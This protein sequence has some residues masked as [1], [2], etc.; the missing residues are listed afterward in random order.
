MPK[1]TEAHLEARRQQIV[2]AAFACFARNGFHRTTM[3]DICQEAELSPG[4][5]YHYFDSKEAII[6]ASIAECQR[7]SMAIIQG[8]VG[9][10]RTLQVLDE[11]L[12]CLSRLSE[13]DARD[14]IRVGV[15]LWAEALRNPRVSEAYRRMSYDVWREALTRIASQGQQQGEIDEDLDPEAVAQVL[16]S[17]WH[18]LGLQKGIDPDLDIAGYS[19]VVR[20]MYGGTFWRDG[21]EE[22]MEENVR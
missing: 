21:G 8:A 12:T 11:L 5:V 7:Q 15:E 2:D 10:G 3:Q 19:Q 17:L 6:E 18:G 4:A 1:V 20:A 14:G 22:T 13:P 16:L 9:K